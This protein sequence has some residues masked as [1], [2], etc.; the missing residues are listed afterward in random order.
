[1]SLI[2]YIIQNIS[3][4]IT[5]MLYQTHFLA[6]GTQ[7]NFQYWIW[8]LSLMF[9]SPLLLC[10]CKLNLLVL[11]F[12]MSLQWFLGCCEHRDGKIAFFQ[13]KFITLHRRRHDEL[14]SRAQREAL[15]WIVSWKPYLILQFTT[16]KSLNLSPTTAGRKTGW[17]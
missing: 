11:K 15:C 2:G 5:V 17:I 12:A 1:M 6:D 7:H 10:E 9:Q 14:I 13:S 8:T 3:V 4:A 16:V